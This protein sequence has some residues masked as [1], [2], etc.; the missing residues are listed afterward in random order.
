MYFDY[1][2]VNGNN[3]NRFAKAEFDGKEIT[4]F[5]VITR[6]EANKLRLEEIGFERYRYYPDHVKRSHIIPKE[7]KNKILED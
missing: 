6:E 4:N 2:F 3:F 7:Y 5:R 1:L